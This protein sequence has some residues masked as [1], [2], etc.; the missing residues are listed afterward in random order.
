MEYR[1]NKKVLLELLGNWNSFIKRKIHLV[2][3]GGTALT[4]LDIKA[5]TKGVDFMV[6]VEA[7]YRYLIKTL[8]NLGYEQIT[9]S[10]W[11]R[12]S[13][14]F[15]FDLF[16][17][18]RIHTTELLES[19]LAPGNH[20]LLKEFSRL[21]IGVLNEY[22]LIASKLFR[23]TEVDFA[24]CLMLVRVKINS[25]DINHLKSHYLELASYD[26]SEERLTRNIDSFLNQI[27]KD[28]RYG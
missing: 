3:C 7:E 2:A 4:L 14:P 23:G 6:P 15:V 20:T 16:M 12:K 24:D 8:Q 9:G 10:G 28:G 27:H 21:Y 18:N 5:S 13:E 1:L 11:S 17:G 25:L 26:V 22:D 19:P